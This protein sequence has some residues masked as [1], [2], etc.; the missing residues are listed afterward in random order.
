MKR[1]RLGPKLALPA[2]V[3]FA[4]TPLAAPAQE[5][6]APA[7]AAETAAPFAAEPLGEGALA[8]I[9]GREERPVWQEASAT[10]NASSRDNSVGDHSPTGALTVSDSAFENLSGI[11]MVNLNTGNASSINATLNVNL[12][13]SSAPLTPPGQ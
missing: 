4:V 11:S 5:V 1:H 8:R 6:P 10:S 12:S 13:I 9:S 3:A 2:A 7:A